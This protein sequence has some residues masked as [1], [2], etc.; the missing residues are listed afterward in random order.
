MSIIPIF[1]TF[2]DNYSPQCAVTI[3]SL[4]SNKHKTVNYKL[5]VISDD[6]SENNK[7]KIMEIVNNFKDSSLK[8]IKGENLIFFEYHQ[9]LQNKKFGDTILTKEALYRCYPDLI[10]EFNK[11]DKIIYSDVDIVVKKDI[12]ELYEIGR[13]HV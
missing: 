7:N 10:T 8:F 5:Y 9:K 2:N 6:I 1:F 3:L 12:S 4:L 13:A 11:Y